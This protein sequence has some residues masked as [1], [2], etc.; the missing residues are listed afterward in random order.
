MSK[1][2]GNGDLDSK[3]L[4]I[5]AN[6]QAVD[7]SE[8]L[9]GILEVAG[10]ASALAA[11]NLIVISAPGTG[12][13][14]ILY[15]MGRRMFGAASMKIECT[16]SL[17]E[18]RIVGYQ[19]PAYLLDA[20]AAKKELPYWI[21]DNTPRDPN[22][23]HVVLAE[24]SR[25]GDLANDALIHVLDDV[26]E[27][28]PVVF[29]ADSNWLTPTQRNQALRDRFAMT[30][31]YH[32]P[33]VDIKAVMRKRP[34]KDWSFNVPEHDAIMQ[35]RDWAS[36]WESY[37]E[38]GGDSQE[39]E[40][41]WNALEP[42]QRALTGTSFVINHRR[43]RQWQ[44]V[45]YSV[46]AYYAGSPNFNQL[47]K[48]AFEALAYCYPCESAEEAQRWYA[49]VMAGVDTVATDVAEF[50]AQAYVEWNDLYEGI[51]K[52]RNPQMR[53]QKVINDLGFKFS[54]AQTEL[55]RRHGKN[56]VKVEEALGN[57]NAMFSAALRGEEFI[58]R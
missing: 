52:E 53:Q 20:D 58:K 38:R 50:L 4:A 36:Q 8:H 23:E 26:N 44:T 54:A 27:Y 39:L 35:V 32:L 16:P 18:E 14:S 48:E 51:K 21:V 2:N 33:I 10:T 5:M 56:N 46:G 12:K 6:V 42:I 55:R 30:V 34:I 28:A 19:N 15:Y 11:Q 9:K 40:T 45:L 57:L 17:R 47:P 29:W 7:T 37:S 41:I 31:Y 13:T 22:V 25:V 43:I 3:A 1:Q 49:I 24:L